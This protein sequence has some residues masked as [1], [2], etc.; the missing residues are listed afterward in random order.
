M[1]TNRYPGSCVTCGTRVRAGAGKAV[2]NGAKW[3]VLCK[4]DAP[5]RAVRPGE[6][7]HDVEMNA[8]GT[9]PSAASRA[10]Y[11]YFPSTGETVY[12][13]ANGL[14]EDAPCCGCCGVG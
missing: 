12:R 4:V 9:K 7:A 8:R 2:R 5:A 3:V 1:I 10:P 6:I 11:A 14:C 13:N